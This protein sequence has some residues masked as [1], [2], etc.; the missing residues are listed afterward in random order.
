M[1][2]NK[3]SLV[4][5]LLSAELTIKEILEE[6]PHLS[7]EDILVCV[8]YGAEVSRERGSWTYLSNVRLECGSFL[9]ESAGYS[10]EGIRVTIPDFTKA[11]L[12]FISSMSGARSA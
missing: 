1:L 12:A 10:S 8:A 5:D 6:C 9:E 11:S 4:L 7:R 2:F 3:F